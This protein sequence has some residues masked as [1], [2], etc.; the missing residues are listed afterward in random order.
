[1]RQ[2]YKSTL[3]FYICMLAWNPFI[4]QIEVIH[5]ITRLLDYNT[6]TWQSSIIILD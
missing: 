1:M 3:P 5:F 4:Q 6:G 2:L